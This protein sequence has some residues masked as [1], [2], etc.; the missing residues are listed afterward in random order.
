MFYK[1]L[2]EGNLRVTWTDGFA[3]YGMPLGL[4]AQQITSYLGA[5]IN[6]FTQNPL[7]SYNIVVFLGAFFSNLT[8][9]FFLRL[10]FSQESSLI[11]TY[12]FNFAPYRIINIYIRG[13]LPEFFA[14]VWL[15]IL[16]LSI[17]KFLEKRTFFYFALI[18]LSTA[19]IILTHPFMIIIYSFIVFLFTL[20]LIKKKSKFSTK[21]LNFL[22]KKNFHLF[23]AFILGLFLSFYFIFP[24]NIELRYF[25]Y[26]RNPNHFNPDHFLTLKNF[27]DP[28]WYYFYQNDIAPRGHFMKTGIIDLLLI[29]SFWIYFI[30]KK[31]F[32][33][34]SSHL[35]KTIF[36]ASFLY[37]F[38]M[39]SYSTFLYQKI[40]FLGNIQH[41]WR[42]LSGFIFLPPIILSFFLEKLKNHRNKLIII[43]SLFIIISFSRIP[44]LY[45]KN[46]QLI[47]QKNYFFTKE[48]LH[49]VVLNTVWTDKSENYPIKKVKAEIVEGNGKIII[50]EVKNNF[51]KY[52]VV[53]ETPV[54]LADYTFYFPGWRVYAN[55]KRVPIQFQDPNYR[56]VIT[57]QLPSGK[58]QVL[59]KFEETIFRIIGILISLMTL[60][61]L[62]FL[63]V[64]RKVFFAH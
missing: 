43:Y 34:K 17:K 49:A 23:F 29:I 2:K 24:L 63:Y 36:I 19:L 7:L 15:P 56:G 39:T 54:R 42:M 10:Y 1:S 8:L 58:H 27:I 37:L 26:G 48:N 22:D 35:L 32:R 45:G 28:N 44:Q 53:A 50:E 46:Y 62:F 12:L 60:I 64:K 41:H 3:N 14:S 21:T 52:T 30:K 9:Y 5:F 31:I 13:A 55:G 40:N 4:M 57:Y 11:A 18:T 61:F 51:R 59:V 47:D 25:Y 6:F 33:E 38:F 20:F 16:L